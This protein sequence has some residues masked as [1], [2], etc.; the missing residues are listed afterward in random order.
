MDLLLDVL[1]LLLALE[2]LALGRRQLLR[3]IFLGL[4]AC[5]F[6][7]HGRNLHV[8]EA[9]TEGNLDEAATDA[10]E[11]HIGATENA[12]LDDRLAELAEEVLRARRQLAEA[13]ALA[14][15]GSWEWDIPRNLVWWSD[16]LYRIYGLEPASIVPT[17]EKLLEYVHTEDRDSVDSRNRKAF[18]DHQPFNDIKRIVRADGREILMSTHGDVVVGDSG[19]P[20]RMIG[21]CEDVT[22]RERAWEA[23]RR[24]AIGS[25]ARRHSVA[26]N[27][28]L[29]DR[30]AECRARL[31]AGAPASEAAGL[32]GDAFAQ[33]RRA[34]DE[35]RRAGS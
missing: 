13:Q 17:Y 2:L 32:V 20:V 34:N 33:L 35:L 6:L 7:R 27:E 15:I 10:K 4:L 28:E 21:I 19:E 12:G 24:L 9:A 8:R 29:I 22:D 16:E 1:E 11:G 23:E 5:L 31:D 14:R 25:D 3:G 30:L 18:A 26:L